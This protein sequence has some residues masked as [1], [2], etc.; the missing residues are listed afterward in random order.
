MNSIRFFLVKTSIIPLPTLAFNEGIITGIIDILQ[1]FT[2]Q[3]AFTEE[4]VCD[5]TIVMRADLL[6]INNVTQ[7][8]F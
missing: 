6:T 3:L 4:M 5:K 8:L 1:T 7:T 2:E